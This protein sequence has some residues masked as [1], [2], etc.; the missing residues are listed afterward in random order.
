MELQNFTSIL[1]IFATFSLA[2]IIIDEL[3]ENPFISLVSENILKKYKLIKK[4]FELLQAEVTGLKTSLNNL[5][6][7]AGIN[8]NKAYQDN[9]DFM[10]RLLKSTNER[11]E[12]SLA[13]IKNKI[14]NNHATQMFVYLN[15]YLFLYCIILLFSAGFYSSTDKK[16]NLILDSSLA[17]FYAG[18]LLYLI[19]CWI[20]ET[21]KKEMDEEKKGPFFKLLESFNGYLT[22][23]GWISIL[24][25]ISTI[26]FYYGFTHS[27]FSKPIVHNTLL[28]LL[29]TLPLINFLI[30]IIKANNRAKKILPNL[31]DTVDQFVKDYTQELH[32]VTAFVTTCN[33]IDNGGPS[34]QQPTSKG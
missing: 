9:Y 13:E 2:Y 33:F 24:S 17:L 28:I 16:L 12:Q 1:E 11:I 32:K 5:I 10:E 34:I 19:S 8:E 30:Y 15:C 3:T 6:H 26:I 18:S 21:I 4:P 20:M 31:R 27:A 22:A 25:I 23:V 14:R 7:L 29:L